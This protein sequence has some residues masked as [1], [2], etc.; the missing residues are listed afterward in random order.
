MVLITAARHEGTIRVRQGRQLG[1]AEFGPP[2]GQALFWMHGTPGARRQV[3]EAARLIA[4]DRGLRII[5]VDRPGVGLS[6]PHL[7][8]GIVDSAADLEVVADRL[9][10]DRFAVVGLSGGGPYALAAAHEMPDR[11]PA[12]GI[13]G[14]VAPTRGPDGIGGGAVGIATRLAPILPVLRE[15]IGAL[16]TAF[17]RLA[18]PIGP[19][20]LDLYGRVSPE[21]DREVLKRPEIKAMFLDDLSNNGGRSMRAVMADVI[22][23]TRDWGFSVRDIEAPV[24]WW[25]GDADH[26]V[27]LA[28]GQHVVPL[29]PKAELRIRAGES[30]L[31]GLGGAAEVLDTVLDWA[32]P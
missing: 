3:P 1:I 16:L 26:I 5:G 28:H 17:V 32:H 10:I 25:H 15:P 19:L 7:Y 31:G 8:D 11:V 6:T 27:P 13:L 24:W 9:G 30:H 12:V 2:D 21:G 14:G 29:I 20:A 22:L 4:A 18:R 23:F